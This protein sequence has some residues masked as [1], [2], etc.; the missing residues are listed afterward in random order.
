ME[1]SFCRSKMERRSD[2]G[3]TFDLI[4]IPTLQEQ[5]QPRQRIFMVK[6]LC[7]IHGVA[8]VAWIE[9]KKDWGHFIQILLSKTMYSNE[10]E[11]QT[12]NHP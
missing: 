8:Y 6:C 10:V 5:N 4:H 2:W 12:C 7:D 11:I 1:D 9:D 3:L